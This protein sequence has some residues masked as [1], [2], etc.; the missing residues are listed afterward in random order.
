MGI[1]SV[2]EELAFIRLWLGIFY[3]LAVG[4]LVASFQYKTGSFANV[5]LQLLVF[6]FMF[7]FFY[8]IKS[9]RNAVNKLKELEEPEN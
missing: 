1:E 6:V 5:T 3:T 4:A 7:V 8:L 9:H 2:K